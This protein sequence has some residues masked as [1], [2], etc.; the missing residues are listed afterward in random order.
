MNTE[1]SKK[2]GLLRATIKTQR[3]LVH[4]ITN[5]VTAGFCA[6]M[7]LA[8][9]ASPVMAD[10]LTE[11]PDMTTKADALVINLGTIN[12]TKFASML[13]AVEV[14]N[15]E[16]IPV[17]FDP[18][19]V[20][21]TS[22]RLQAANILLE[23]GVSVIRGNLSECSALLTN[24]ATGKGVDSILDETENQGQ[25]A[26]KVAQQYN[27][28]CAVTG[29]VDALSDGKTTLLAYNGDP[30]LGQITGTGCMTTTLIGAALGAAK[31]PLV[32][33]T[34]GITA[35]NIAGQDAARVSKGPGS[36]RANLL[37]AVYGLMPS[38]I[39]EGFRGEEV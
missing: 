21:A 19:G 13:K 9:G 37:D 1:F 20:M 7:A 3:P 25:V 31:D 6:D 8:I 26:Q 14:A 30:M 24:M 16:H 27:C 10:E 28:V 22:Y 15:C 34:F 36:F 2:L 4:H 12:Q 17:V 29:K 18:V 35:M 5:Y 33:A 32:A 11:M 38:D 39:E 23:M